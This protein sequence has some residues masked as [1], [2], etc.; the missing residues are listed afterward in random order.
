MKSSHTPKNADKVGHSKFSIMKKK[1]KLKDKV[2][3]EGLNQGSDDVPVK[4]D[5]LDAEEQDEV[6]T[7]NVAEAQPGLFLPKTKNQSHLFNRSSPMK[8]VRVCKSMTP[9][10][11]SLLTD[12]NFGAM[13]Q[14]KCS[15]LIPE[16]CRFLMGCFDPEKCQFDFGDRGAIPVTVESFVKVLG[17]PMGSSPVPYHLDVEATSLMLNMLGITDGVQPNVT[18]LEMELGKEHPADDAYLRKFVIYMMSSVFAPTTGIKVSPKCYPSVLNIEAIS[19]LNWARFIIDILIETANAKDKKNWFKACMP[20]IMILYVDS[21]QTEAVDLPDDVTRCIVWTNQLISLVAGLDKTSNGSFGALPLKPCFRKKLFLFNPEPEQVDMF[22]RRHL[23]GSHTH[24]DLTKY[25]PA[26]MN[27]CSVLEDGLASFIQSL[28]ENVPSTK[29]GQ[30]SAKDCQQLPKENPKRRKYVRATTIK[31]SEGGKKQEVHEDTVPLDTDFSETIPNANEDQ[32]RKRKLVENGQDDQPDAVNQDQVKEKVCSEDIQLVNHIAQSSLEEMVGKKED[33]AIEEDVHAGSIGHASNIRNVTPDALK[34]LQ[35]YGSGSN[36]SGS[37]FIPHK[38]AEADCSPNKAISYFQDKGHEGSINCNVPKT[39]SSGKGKKSVTFVLQ[40][41]HNAV[42]AQVAE[43]NAPAIVPAKEAVQCSPMS[44]L[45][46]SESKECSPKPKRKRNSIAMQVADSPRRMTRFA[47]A[48]AREKSRNAEMPSNPTID[49]QDSMNKNLELQFKLSENRPETSNQ[50]NQRALLEYYPPFDLG[51]DEHNTQETS[52]VVC[53]ETEIL[54]SNNDEFIVISS[55]EESGDSLDKI[56]T[57]VEMPIRTPIIGKQRVPEDDHV[58][59]VGQNSSTPIPEAHKKRIVKPAQTQKSP[60]VAGTK[61][62]TAT[63]YATEVYNRLCSYGGETK[64]ELNKRRIIDDGKFF[65]YGRDLAD[66]VRPGA[67]L[68]NTTCELAIHVLAPEMEKQKK[69][70]MPLM[71]ATKLRNVMCIHDR[72]ATKAFKMTSENRLDHKEQMSW[73]VHRRERV[74]LVGVNN[75]GKTTQLRIISDPED[76]NNVNVAKGKGNMKIGLLSQK[77]QVCASQ[78]A[79]EGIPECL[80]GGDGR[81]GLP[82]PGV[83]SFLGLRMEE[84]VP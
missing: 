24:E 5:V 66:S 3:E 6:P 18:S 50:R 60:F 58:T 39:N 8:L 22:I 26:V 34:Q 20:Y 52:A 48:E 53:K 19:T 30:Q 84:Q 21:L 15:K 31:Q 49:V 43:A 59:S 10:Q 2:D 67:W 57:N 62:E 25:R 81:Q 14:M 83:I 35:S 73:E 76:P 4:H 41:E 78:T 36:S 47:T 46:P 12:A 61:K 7:G 1:L 23:P 80:I 42:P 72:V 45:K 64:N 63:K 82:R 27:M 13:I 11:R 51:F 44:A 32:S 65:I 68:S 9:E 54:V 70:V 40:A 16:L 38:V 56:Y 79:K 74:G 37:N 71:M 75:T 28:G 77:I 29:P 55:N 33:E 17:L 69:F